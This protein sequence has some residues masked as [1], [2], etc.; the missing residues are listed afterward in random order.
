MNKVQRC[1][2][3]KPLRMVELE[4]RIK[5]NWNYEYELLEFWIWESLNYVYDRVGIMNKV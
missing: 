4:L 1:A 3:K 5:Q 2:K